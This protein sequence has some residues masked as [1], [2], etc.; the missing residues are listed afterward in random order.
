MPRAQGGSS[1]VMKWLSALVVFGLGFILGGWFVQPRFPPYPAPA[2]RP[3]D[4]GYWTTNWTGA[5]I[6]LLLAVLSLKQTRP[7]AKH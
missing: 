4:L 7:R 5:L 1:A 6:G 3:W 2:V